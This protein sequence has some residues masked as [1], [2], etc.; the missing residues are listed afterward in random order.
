MKSNANCFSVM[1]YWH[2]RRVKYLLHGTFQSA[3][4][5]EYPQAIVTTSDIHTSL[6]ST[7]EV[8]SSISD[9][10]T[11]SVWEMGTM[12]DHFSSGSYETE[13]KSQVGRGD[14]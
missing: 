9:S 4:R 1:L 11:S 3:K 2:S 5:Q 13:C 8:G 7:P 14:E 12:R 10:R 6:L